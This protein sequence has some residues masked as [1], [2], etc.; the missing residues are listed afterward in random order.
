M[1]LNNNH[2]TNNMVKH[3]GSSKMISKVNNKKYI[4]LLKRKTDAS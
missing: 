3:S 1:D 4:S 2:L